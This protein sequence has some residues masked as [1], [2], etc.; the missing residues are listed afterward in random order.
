MLRIAVANLLARKFRL[1]SSGAAVVIGV[2]FLA[3]TLALTDTIGRTF[4]DLFSEVT[5]GVDANVRSA[6]SVESP[7]GDLRGPVDGALLEVVAGGA[8]VRAADG[9]VNGYAQLVAP[10]G[11]PMGN[12]GQ[13]A[14]TLG[15]SWPTVD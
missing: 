2:A 10:D 9:D 6:D 13:G 1:V 4:D 14:P 12:P 15:N 3:G 11:E 8:G 7:F 5:A